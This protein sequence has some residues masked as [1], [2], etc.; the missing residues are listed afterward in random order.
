VIQGSAI[1]SNNGLHGV[2]SQEIELYY[3]N[4]FMAFVVITSFNVSE[5]LNLLDKKIHWEKAGFKE[6]W[7][8]FCN[9]LKA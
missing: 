3:S 9:S 1:C 2:I 8:I 4:M 5:I 7:S 6:V